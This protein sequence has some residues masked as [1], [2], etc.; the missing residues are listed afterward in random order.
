M[1]VME[2]NLRCFL[3][4]R[5]ASDGEL[6]WSL[7]MTS[8]PLV[9]KGGVIIRYVRSTSKSYRLEPM[10]G[11]GL[12]SLCDAFDGGLVPLALEGNSQT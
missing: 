2:H 12:L 6:W 10:L 11:D 1:T 7:E 3:P 5:M 8:S 9:V 4:D